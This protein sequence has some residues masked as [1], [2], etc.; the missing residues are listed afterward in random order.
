MRKL[1]SI[2]FLVSV[3]TIARS[4]NLTFSQALTYNGELPPT[5]WTPGTLY[6]VPNGKVWKIESLFSGSTN[7]LGYKLNNT[8]LKLNG[9]GGASQMVFPI[10]LKPGDTLQPYVF[11]NTGFSAA[12]VYFISIVEFSTN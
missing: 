12:L 4:Q 9:N 2:L 8:M 3:C 1:L 11:D 5:P 7:A 10:W 6:T